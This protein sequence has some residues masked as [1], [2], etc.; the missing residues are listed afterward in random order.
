M[1][2]QKKFWWND[3]SD[4]GSYKFCFGGIWDYDFY[5]EEVAVKYKH[6]REAEQFRRF[7][8]AKFVWGGCAGGIGYS[9]HL[10]KADNIDDAKKEF[11]AWYEQYLAGR[12]EN[13]KM[14]L[15]TALEDCEEFLLYKRGNEE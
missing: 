9:D 6:M 14:A 2:G 3:D 13:L 11:E 15:A 8:G 7:K 5:I 4:I 12:V 1:A 10:L